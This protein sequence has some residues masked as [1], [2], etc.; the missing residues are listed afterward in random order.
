MISDWLFHDKLYV[1]LGIQFLNCQDKKT[2]TDWLRDRK[3][4]IERRAR[5]TCIDSGT[6]SCK[7]PLPWARR[8]H[9]ISFSIPE[10]RHQQAR[11]WEM[12]IKKFICYDNKV[13]IL[14]WHKSH[15]TPLLPPPPPPS[16]RPKKNCIGIVFVSLLGHLHVPGEMANNEYAKFRGLKE[17]Y[18]G[19]CASRELFL[20]FVKRSKHNIYFFFVG[21]DRNADLSLDVQNWR[22]F[23]SHKFVLVL[24]LLAKYGV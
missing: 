21:R 23:S 15:K 7:E 5:R 1:L 12:L 8:L 4:N 18:Y 6:W 11:D 10:C 20:S 22:R 24:A 14:Y 3:L 9:G 13:I 16:P 2:D 19:I 17:L